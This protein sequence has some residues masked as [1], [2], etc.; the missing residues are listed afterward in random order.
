MMSSTMSFRKKVHIKR[1]PVFEPN[2]WFFEHHQKDGEEKWQTYA[3]VVRD[4]LAEVGNLEKSDLSVEDKFE[5]KRLVN[6]S[7]KAKNN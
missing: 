2:D 1:L 7:S 6:P 3:R 4:I 5:Y